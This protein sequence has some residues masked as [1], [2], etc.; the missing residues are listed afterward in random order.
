MN[1]FEKYAQNSYWDKRVTPILNQNLNYSDKINQ[2]LIDRKIWIV[3]QLIKK[4]NPKSV[5]DAG[6]G[7]GGVLIPLAEKYYGTIDWYGIDFSKGNIQELKRNNNS[8]NI[9]ATI[10]NITKIHYTKKSFDL[11]FSFDVLCH[12]KFNMVFDAITEFHRVSKNQCYVFDALEYTILPK[13]HFMFSKIFPQKIADYLTIKY[14]KKIEENKMPV[15]R[16]LLNEN[17]NK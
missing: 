7:S 5:L 15:M 3:E 1:Q 4:L 11:L 8:R 13:Y 16:G 6:C 9:I 17:K 2:Y 10:D 12:L 14:S